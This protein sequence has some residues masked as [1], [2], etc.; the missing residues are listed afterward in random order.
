RLWALANRQAHEALVAA[1]E[2]NPSP[3][4]QSD[5]SVD[6]NLSDMVAAARDDLVNA[7]FTVFER[8]QPGLV[9]GRYTIATEATLRRGR[10]VYSQV[11]TLSI[12]LP[13]AAIALFGLAFL[14]S[15]ERRRTLVR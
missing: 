11:E 4:V 14:I 7:G 3:L 8:I 12:V 5:G 2:G 10:R 13:A 15:R 1:L 9:Q 6:L